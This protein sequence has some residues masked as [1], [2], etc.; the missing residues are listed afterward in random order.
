MNYTKTIRQFCT[1]NPDSLF[2]V[3]YMATDYFPMVP[4]KTLLRILNRLEEE[5][6]LIPV[7]KGVYY[8]KGGKEYDLDDAIKKYYV[9]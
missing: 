6:V 9:V 2:D 1:M 8:I 4:Y 7:S 3:S 5:E